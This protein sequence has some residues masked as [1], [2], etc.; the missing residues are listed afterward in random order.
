[1]ALI[2]EDGTGKADAQSFIS[3]ADAN[4]YASNR[5]HSGWAGAA[6][7]D[8]EKALIKATDFL[9]RYYIWVGTKKTQ[10]QALQWPRSGAEDWD[11]YSIAE[12]VVP[13]AVKD[14]CVEL[15]TRALTKDL[16]PDLA[17]GGKVSSVTAGSVSVRFTDDAPVNKVYQTVDMLLRGLIAPSSAALRVDLSKIEPAE[18]EPAFTLGLH[19]TADETNDDEIIL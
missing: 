6:D 16:L 11:G 8:K 9:C 19:D 18:A 10:A 4:T 15:A 14:A 13:K 1:M 17:R 7:A 3:V 2:V 12:N 5:G